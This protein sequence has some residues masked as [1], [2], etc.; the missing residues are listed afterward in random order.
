MIAN[1]F[2][3]QKSYKKGMLICL[4]RGLIVDSTN[5]TVYERVKNFTLKVVKK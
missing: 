1:K 4:M 3:Q 2:W 5:L